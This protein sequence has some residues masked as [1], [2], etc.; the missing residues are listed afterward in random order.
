MNALDVVRAAM[1]DATEEDAEFIVWARTP[2]PMVEGAARNIYRAASGWA[3]ATRNGR[4]LCDLCWRAVTGEGM[5]CETCMRMLEECRL[6]EGAQ[7]MIEDL[8]A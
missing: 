6:Y 7:E 3:R 4:V 2:F 5:T 8:R 1:P